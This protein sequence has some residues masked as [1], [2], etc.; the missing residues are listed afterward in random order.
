M[1]Y[2]VRLGMSTSPAKVP[3]I[4]DVYTPAAAQ[5]KAKAASSFHEGIYHVVNIN[6]GCGDLLVYVKPAYFYVPA[7]SAYLLQG[8]KV[9]LQAGFQF[10][11][12]D[13]IADF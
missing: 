11:S 2:S 1:R 9:L 10:H 4:R 8:L 12:S 3:R 7:V 6:E 5:K 13:P